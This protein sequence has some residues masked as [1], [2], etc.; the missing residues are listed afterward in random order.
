MPVIYSFL[1]DA[2]SRV[3]SYRRCEYCLNY[4]PETHGR[5]KYCPH[6]V[7]PDRES[8]CSLNY[9]QRKRRRAMS[10]KEET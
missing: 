8:L 3:R 1:A 10:Q 7:D 2:V 5:Q 4:F 6:P 9:R